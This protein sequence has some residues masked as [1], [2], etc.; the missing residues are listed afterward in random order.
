LFVFLG[1][2]VEGLTSIEDATPTFCQDVWRNIHRGDLLLYVGIK[3]LSGGVLYTVF[4]LGA[5]NFQDKT[6]ALNKELAN[7]SITVQSFWDNSW[8]HESHGHIFFQDQSGMF[9]DL[10]D[11]R[12]LLWV[13]HKNVK[14]LA[15][16]IS[17]FQTD[18]DM[19]R[20]F[21]IKSEVKGLVEYIRHIM[22]CHVDLYKILWIMYFGLL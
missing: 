18:W 13:C 6:G 21:H 2:L 1:L 3:P 11:K 15:D 17:G 19:L 12:W 5:F 8:T 4:M 7:R 14:E 20:I 16:Y 22:G 10:F 9:E